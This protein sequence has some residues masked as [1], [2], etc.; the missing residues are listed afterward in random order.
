MIKSLMAKVRIGWLLT[1]AVCF[2]ISASAV[3]IPDC[4]E[5]GDRAANRI[6]Q[7][8]QPTADSPV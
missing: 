3:G 6:W 8:N 1:G 4:V 7:E 2:V 5:A